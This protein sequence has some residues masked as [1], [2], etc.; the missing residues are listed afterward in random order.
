[1]RRGCGAG[2]ARLRGGGVAPD[3]SSAS[4]SVQQPPVGLGRTSSRSLTDLKAMRMRMVLRYYN[5]VICVLVSFY[6]ADANSVISYDPSSYLAA[7]AG[8]FTNY[9]VA[10]HLEMLRRCC[11]YLRHHMNDTPT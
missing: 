1:M 8:S 3:A 7:D 6:L 9:I 2:A 4:I 11:Y 5:A 10:L